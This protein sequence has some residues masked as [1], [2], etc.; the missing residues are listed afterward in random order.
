MNAPRDPFNKKEDGAEGKYPPMTAKVRSNVELSEADVFRET[1]K[2]VVARN[3]LDVDK[4]LL[5]R[6]IDAKIA[7]GDMLFR[8]GNAISDMGEPEAFN[9]KRPNDKGYLVDVGSTFQKTIADFA[10]SP[11]ETLDR[12]EREKQPIE[13][14]AQG[15]GSKT[16]DPGA[17]G[18]TPADAGGPSSGTATGK[19][20]SEVPPNQPLSEYD[21]PPGKTLGEVAGGKNPQL[22]DVT[23]SK[24]ASAVYENNAYGGTPEGWRA[25]NEKDIADRL[26]VAPD[27]PKVSDWFRKN[28]GGKYAQEGD[29]TKQ[30]EFKAEIYTDGKGN[31]VLAYRGTA[32]GGPDWDN[33]FQQA[34]GLTT[35]GDKDKFSGT[36]VSTAKEFLKMFGQ[37]DASGRP[38]NLAMVGHSQGGGLAAMGSVATGVPAVTFDAS[39]IHPN[40]LY[41]IQVTLGEARKYAENGGI[42]AYSLK[43]D[44]LTNVQESKG[45]VGFVAPDA[46]GT[47]I[48]LNPAKGKEGRLMEEYG[49]SQIPGP[50]I[51]RQVIDK[52]EV[53]ILIGTCTVVPMPLCPV[54]GPV[55]ARAP[56]QAIS[57][58]PTALTDALIDHKP[59]VPKPIP[60]PGPTPTPTPTPTPE[61]TTTKIGPIP[62]P[63]PTPTPTPTPTPENTTTKIGPIPQPLPTP[64]PKSNQ[65]PNNLQSSLDDPAHPRNGMFRKALGLIQTKDTELGRGSDDTTMRLAAGVTAEARARGLDT[66]AFAQFSEDGRRFLMADT[67]DPSLPWARTAVGD[68]GQ[69]LQQ[70]VGDST[71]RI[72]QLD[73]AQEL[74]RQQS[75]PT[76]QQDLKQS[77]PV[78]HGPRLV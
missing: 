33:N 35:D 61:N 18:N 64:T 67:R 29:D 68:V 73:Q 20:S 23:L 71:Q 30:Q 74:A 8:G 22:I 13:T 2:Q 19:S 17:P 27:D 11:T 4:E 70:N 12:I 60:S 78:I 6:Y 65:E 54:V 1:V 36:A 72:A 46:L 25:I 77:G 48:R 66:I 59:W 43:D 51:V 39:G 38:T 63:G 34:R 40:T 10:K 42:R 14:P 56:N 41:R 5:E 31:F 76:E 55:L 37:P 16:S 44:A 49:E 28:L 62:S 58:F 53:P 21:V 57:H 32:E 75:Q 50:K 3:K 45:I 26:G 69:A 15:S 52:G 9:K 24:L 7:S 47:K